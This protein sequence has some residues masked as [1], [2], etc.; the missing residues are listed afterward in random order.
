[1]S[2]S[3]KSA[4]A[5]IMGYDK[6]EH[7]RLD[8]QAAGLEEATC[9]ALKSAGVKAGWR[10]LDVACG[11]GSVTRLLGEIVG[12]S[13]KVHSVDLDEKYGEVAIG[14]M[15]AAG[16]SIYS[17]Q[18]FDVTSGDLPD[19]APFDFVFTRLLLV[20]MTDPDTVLK[21]LWSWV[22]PG[23][24]LMVMDYD[25]GVMLLNSDLKG[26]NDAVPIL[27]NTFS[28]LGKNPRIGSTLANMFLQTGIGDAD[29]TKIYGKIAKPNGILAAA[30]RSM[31]PAII[32]SGVANSEKM[33][34]VLLSLDQ[35]R[36]EGRTVR[37]EPDMIAT[38][39][40]KSH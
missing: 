19:G 30:L 40:H 24:A 6:A 37:R 23:G 13:G 34:A 7:E 4:N 11:T 16:P 15:N 10:C 27:L 33:D 26:V 17:F 25:M 31:R 36:R 29:G 1:M 28:A 9:D 14:Q 2:N 38:W 12:P 3:D 18:K 5:Y 39:K 20:H 21:R 8:R 22:K 32:K 35:Y